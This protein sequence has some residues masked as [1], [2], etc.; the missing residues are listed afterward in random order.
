M[1]SATDLTRFSIRRGELDDAAELAA[2]AARTFEEAFGANNRPDDIQAHN[3]AAYGPGRQAEEL[4][5]P[6]V[7]TI[8][9]HSGKTLIAYAQVR[10]SRPPACVT[11]E[12]PIEL[13]RL[14]VDRPAHGSG[15]ASRLMQT[16]RNAATELQARHIWL[17]VWEQ[18]PRAIAFY[19]KEGFV[20]VGSTYFTVGGDRQTDRVLVACAGAGTPR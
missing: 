11:H 12:A 13:H 10:R 2:F 14:Y 3:S 19:N 16:V 20:D 9:A 5:D 1:T 6:S 4:T 18:N 15:L 8:L 7:I 17:G